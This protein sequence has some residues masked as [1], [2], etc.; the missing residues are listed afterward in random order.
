MR[1][2]EIIPVPP[3][4]ANHINLAPWPT[5]DCQLQTL[6]L[7]C[8]LLLPM[9]AE[10]ADAQVDRAEKIIL[11]RGLHHRVIQTAKGG[12][13]TELSTGMHFIRDSQLFESQENVLIDANGYGVADQGQHS[14]RFS[15][16]ITDS[17]T[18]VYTDPDGNQMKIRPLCLAFRTLQLRKE[19]AL[20]RNQV[21]HWF[22]TIEC[23]DLCRCL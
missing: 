9:F 7:A 2:P 14:A 18:A 10:A 4:I 16:S 11:E 8:L 17:P 15:P 5:P 20:L 22:C 1:L 19:R 12:S 21:G 23:C 13:Y 6:L 3:T